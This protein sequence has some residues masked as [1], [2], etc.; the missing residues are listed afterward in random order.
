M[1]CVTRMTWDQPRLVTRLLAA[2]AMAGE[3]RGEIRLGERE[4]S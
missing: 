4:E 2:S 1:F 3:E